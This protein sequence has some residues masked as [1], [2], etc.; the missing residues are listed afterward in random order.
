MVAADVM[1]AATVQ[2]FFN[3][4]KLEGHFRRA[5]AENVKI[6]INNVVGKL[7]ASLYDHSISAVNRTDIHPSFPKY[8]SKRASSVGM[9]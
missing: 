2:Q 1:S 3:K 9:S 6:T 4:S 5:T 8:Q 7:I